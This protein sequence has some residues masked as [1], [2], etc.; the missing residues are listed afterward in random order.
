MENVYH[1]VDES[2]HSSWAEFQVQIGHPIEHKIRRARSVLANDQANKW[3]KAK[4][5]V[6]A[7]SVCCVGQMRHTPEAIKRWESQMEG[8][9]LYSSYQDAVGID[10]EA[11]E[12]EWKMF[13]RFSSMSILG[14]I[15][16]DLETK[17][18]GSER[19]IKKFVPFIPIIEKKRLHNKI[20]PPLQEYL[21]WLSINW[22][23]YSAEEHHQPSSSSS[24]SPTFWW[25]SSSWS[26]NWQR[27]HQ[28]SWQDDR[29]SEQWWVKQPGIRVFKKS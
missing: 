28:H 4:V 18:L 6:Y 16:E 5:C 2:R 7:D 15:E 1:F 26:S 11:I 27:W 10:G 19:A 9:K 20:D 3:V 24:W 12:F 17:V 14:K 8:I 23:D 22:E 21:E 25:S 29:W 13:P